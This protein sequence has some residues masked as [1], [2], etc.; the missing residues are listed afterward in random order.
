M[1]NTLECLAISVPQ[2]A[3]LLGISKNN[4]YI[5]ARREDF[6]AFQVGHRTLV[7]VAGLVKWVEIQAGTEALLK[8]RS[9]E[10]A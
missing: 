6:P 8:K 2:A 9:A 4:A 1:Q 10:A 3:K 5:L 7:S